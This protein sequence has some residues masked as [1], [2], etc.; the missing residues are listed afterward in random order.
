M[1]NTPW[2]YILN[3]IQ[4]PSGQPDE[5]L[6][7]WLEEDEE[8]QSVYDEVKL[9]YTLAG[10][11]PSPFHA[12]KE[13]AWQN[14]VRRISSKQPKNHLVPFLLR[15]A[16]SFLLVA[17]GISGGFLLW[18]KL[19]PETYTEV[20]S[21]YGHKTMVVLPDQSKVWLN[22]DSR[23]KYNTNFSN[24]RKVMLTG[25]ALFEV[26]RN[27]RK[28]FT[29]N[30]NDLMLEVYGT[31]FNVKTY[32]GDETSEVALVEGSVGLF[33][34]NRLL[35]KMVP[36]EIITY[37]AASREFESRR[38]NMSQIT[39]WKG[40]ELV[41]ENETF[42]EMVKYLERWYGVEISLD[43]SLNPNQRLSFKVKTESLTE[44]LSIISRITP[45]E[46]QIDGKKLKISKRTN[47][48]NK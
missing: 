4:N 23:L 1:S 46:Y 5:S 9:V 30:T 16:A 35:K 27:S 21:P 38:G 26:T 15:I 6:K 20:Y 36:G 31:T 18:N 48:K 24:R 32:P 34:E 19:Q 14:I 37:H 45:I 25:E 39:S 42:S 41:I 10:N 33:H 29:V 22:G 13:K 43:Q 7:M 12:Y 44:L 3:K 40:D 17:L 11:V 47:S 28:L 8:N 2:E